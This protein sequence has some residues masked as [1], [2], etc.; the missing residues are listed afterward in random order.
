[1]SHRVM[2]M[3]SND[4]AHALYMD[5][6]GEK[7]GADDE[8]MRPSDDDNPQ[9]KHHTGSQYG[10]FLSLYSLDHK[11]IYPL[12]P[13]YTNSIHSENSTT[14]GDLHDLPA[15]LDPSLITVLVQSMTSMRSLGR[16]N[17]PIE[18]LRI[19]FYIPIE[20]VRIEFLRKPTKGLELWEC[21]VL[22]TIWSRSWIR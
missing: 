15:H 3:Y 6:R 5:V 4:L 7:N 22:L 8:S 2:Y 17:I 18:Y 20:Y 21:V 16:K 9:S 19:E 14:V 13:S 10:F 11:S 12:P 1:M